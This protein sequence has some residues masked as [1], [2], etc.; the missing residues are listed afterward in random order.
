[1]SRYLTGAFAPIGEEYTLTDLPVTG[2]IPD[3]L[4]GRY[5]RNG[6]DPV[7]EIDP[8]LY[9]W[10]VGDGMVHGIRIRDGKAEWYRNRWVRGPETARA[11]GEQPPPG[12]FPVSGIGAN[13]NVIGHAG[14]TIALVEA[15]LACVE[16]TDELATVGACDFDGTLTGG[17]TAHPKRDPETGELHA[18]SYNLFGG[19]R[20]QYSVIGV[21]GRARRVV[22]IPVAG[23]PMMHDFSLT[24][25][26]VVIYDLPV[27][28][29]VRQM[30]EMAV[31]R[32]LRLP[33]RL[34]LSALIGRIRIPDPIAARRPRPST[35]RRF[36]YSWNPNHP[37]RVGV[38]PRDGDGRDVRWF[39]VE[40]CYVFHP[41]NA[42]DD[43]D[44]VVLDV[45]RHPKM[46]DTHRLGP[47]E[48][49]PTL[50]RWVVDLADGK[51]RESRVDDRAQEFPRVDERRVGRRHR[52][53]YAPAFPGGEGSDTLLKHDFAGSGSIQRS[54]G[55]GKVLGEFVFVPSSP[56]AAEDDGV[57][58]G[59][60]YDR[61]T[62]RSEL[63]LLDA[64]TL[65]DVARISLPHRVPAGFHGNWVP[66][67]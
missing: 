33:A 32:P 17:Y 61:P 34:V 43:G 40:P 53:G 24:E 35:D 25:N 57:L 60:V 20:V 12:H 10:F 47:D 19:N 23:A 3:W 50:D 7:G 51:V 56:D 44:T 2:T 5:L 45:V 52:Y 21:D 27:T 29:D 48:G 6:P 67:A 14:K 39:D 16:L 59:F 13:T 58:M 41:L 37:A 42:Y 62:D 4:D 30:A 31:P 9:H 1:M 64:Q 65:Q 46:F 8:E 38:M 15:G 54:F 28:A 55:A 26:H 11:L 66:T 49:D 22:D 36:P 18:V 63:A